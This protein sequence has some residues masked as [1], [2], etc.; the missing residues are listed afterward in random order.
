MAPQP[1]GLHRAAGGAIDLL[2]K[3][4]FAP[5]PE[6][7]RSVILRLRQVP[8]VMQDLRANMTIPPKEFTQIAIEEA[9][10]SVGFF[11]DTLAAWAKDAPVAI[12]RC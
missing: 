1:E 10:G 3:R 11:R 2:I 4:D 8:K 5:G 12:Q 6:R 7:L 9:S